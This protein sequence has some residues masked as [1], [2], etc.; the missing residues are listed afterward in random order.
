MNT[1]AER[2]SVRPDARLL[3]LDPDLDA[4]FAEVEDILRQA[5]PPG[6]GAGRTP[7]PV[8]GHRPG[9]LGG[10][11]ATPRWRGWRPPPLP[12]TGRGPPRR[13]TFRPR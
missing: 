1:T 4:L 13:H 8:A 9:G 11:A 7:I 3:L 10:Q 2:E 6:T 12:P 5:G